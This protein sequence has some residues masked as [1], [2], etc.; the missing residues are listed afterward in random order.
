MNENIYTKEDKSKIDLLTSQAQD[1]IFD[2]ESIS[3]RKYEE[4]E[5]DN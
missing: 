2:T 3:I 1:L 5:G 4:K